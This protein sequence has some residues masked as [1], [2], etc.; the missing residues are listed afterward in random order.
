MVELNAGGHLAAGVAEYERERKRDKSKE[1]TTTTDLMVCAL[2][3]V[4]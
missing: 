1:L 3:M 4:E 2:D